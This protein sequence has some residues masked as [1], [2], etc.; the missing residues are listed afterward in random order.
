MSACVSS[1]RA[2]GPSWRCSSA[3]SVRRPSASR[4]R[5][6][7]G[8]TA[9]GSSTRRGRRTTPPSRG[10]RRTQGAR[11][12]GRADVTFDI[13]FTKGKPEALPLAAAALVKAGVDL[14]FTSNEAAT[15]AAK[16]AT[17]G[18]DRLHPGGR[19]GGC[20]NRRQLAHPGGNLTGVSSLTTELVPKRLE[21]LKTGAGRPPS[22]GD[23]L[24]RRPDRLRDRRK[25]R[26]AAPRLGLDSCRGGCA[27]RRSSSRPSRK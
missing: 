25:A 1:P 9:S 11:P 10:S 8:R 7:A 13:R 14:I 12:R 6:L 24:R 23:L 26:E 16:T 20:G 19:S 2:C 21:V 4:R 5:K 17:Q 18:P 27:P 15:Q 22:A 3:S